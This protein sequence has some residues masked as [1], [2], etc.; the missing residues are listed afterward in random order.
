M[1]RKSLINMGA[2]I[3][4]LPID[5][6][7]DDDD[8]LTYFADNVIGGPAAFNLPVTGMGQ[9]P[10]RVRQKIVLDLY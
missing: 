9:L 2:T 7:P 8:I 3:N 6:N 5:I 1:A 10:T 4:G